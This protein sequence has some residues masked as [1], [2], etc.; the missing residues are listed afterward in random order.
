MYIKNDMNIRKTKQSLLLL[1]LFLVASNN[2]L[3]SQTSSVLKTALKKELTTSINLGLQFL[4]NT[5]IQ[6][7]DTGHFYK[8]EWKTT[9]QMNKSF[10]YLGSKKRKADDSNCFSIASIH[11]ALAQIYLVDSNYTSILKMMDLS[12]NQILSYRKGN[13]FNFWNLLT[14]KIKL[15]KDD[16]IGEQKPIRRPTNFVLK[17]K[18]INNAANI[19]ED[20][21]DTALGYLAI[22]LHN[23]IFDDV[24]SNNSKTRSTDSLDIVFDTYRDINRNNRHW[25]NHLRGNDHETGAFLTWHGDEYEFKNWNILKTAYHNTIWFNK[26]SECYPH[27]YIPYIPYGSNDLDPIVNANIISSLWGSNDTSALG[28]KDAIDYIEYKSDKNQDK[29]G[30]YYSNRY[31]FSYAVSEAYS[32][33]ALEL[34]SA[35]LN[36]VEFINSN[37]NKDGSFSSRRRLNKKDIIQSTAYALNAL[38]NYGDFKN[39]RIINSI[40]SAIVFLLSQSKTDESGLYWP[41]GVFFSGGTVIRNILVWKSDAYTTAIILKAFVKYK[42]YLDSNVK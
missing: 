38:V 36:L 8:G 30:I 21:D 31:H 22:A 15:K 10:F 9:M 7:T 29:I 23:Q 40:E 18:Y 35:M 33:G 28:I 41:G 19:A 14:P 2:L 3:F 42:H 12:F 17:S 32:N 6:F 4:E 5:Q 24:C 13:S 39:G 16:I 26:K 11:N 27:P 20:A 37:Q 25:Y 34:D 1:V